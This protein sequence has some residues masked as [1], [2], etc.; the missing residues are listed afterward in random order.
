M[1]V[2]LP[3]ARCAYPVWLHTDD[4]EDDHVPTPHEAVQ[5]GASLYAIEYDKLSDPL[6][7]LRIRHPS[8]YEP[9]DREA[10]D[11]GEASDGLPLA[12]CERRPRRATSR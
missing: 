11:A 12:V 5:G 1:L 6:R 4:A 3:G 8:R 2:A 7:S 9:L 10:A